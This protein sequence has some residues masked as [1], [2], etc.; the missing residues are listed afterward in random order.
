MRLAKHVAGKMISFAR[1][2]LK[3]QILVNYIKFGDSLYGQFQLLWKENTLVLNKEYYLI[4]LCF[5]WGHFQTV[6]ICKVKDTQT[7]QTIKFFISTFDCPILSANRLVRVSIGWNINVSPGKGKFYY[8]Q[9][10]TKSWLDLAFWVFT[11]SAGLIVKSLSLNRLNR[12]EIANDTSCSV[13]NC[14]KISFVS[15]T[16]C[17]RLKVNRKISLEN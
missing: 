17:S 4:I 14:I 8:S 9:K 5:F 12:V 3:I 7:I 16:S 11:P 6:F 1:K 10:W 15:K 13:S 2:S